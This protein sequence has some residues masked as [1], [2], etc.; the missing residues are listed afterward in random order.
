MSAKRWA[1]VIVVG[2]LALA[3][4]GLLLH[5]DVMLVSADI[6]GAVA[7]LSVVLLGGRRGPALFATRALAMIA[8]LIIAVLSLT[9]HAS[10]WLTALTLAGAFTL[11]FMTWTSLFPSEPRDVSRR[12][13]PA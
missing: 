9:A 10:P 2:M 7:A 11:A 1:V 13:R 4:V 6:L 8:L 12:P 5:T 3:V